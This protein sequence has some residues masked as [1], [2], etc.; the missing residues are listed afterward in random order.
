MTRTPEFVAFV[1]VVVK[2]IEWAKLLVAQQLLNDSVKWS[3]QY[4][5]IANFDFFK[6]LHMNYLNYNY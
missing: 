3:E 1:G 4:V 6:H 5:T 2:V